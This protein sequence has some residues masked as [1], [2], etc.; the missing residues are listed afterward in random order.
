MPIFQRRDKKT[1]GRNSDREERKSNQFNCRSSLEAKV[2]FRREKGKRKRRSALAFKH[3]TL[4]LQRSPKGRP[5]SF[6]S[7]DRANGAHRLIR[8]NNQKNALEKAPVSPKNTPG[9]Q[10]WRVWVAGNG[11]ARVQA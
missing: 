4:A 2:H 8:L 1:P 7:E 6:Y 3:P 5:L 10:S 11:K 9:S